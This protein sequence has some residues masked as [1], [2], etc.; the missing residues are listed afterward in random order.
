MELI[1]NE[2]IEVTPAAAGISPLG[3][4]ASSGRVPISTGSGDLLEGVGVD[5]RMFLRLRSLGKAAMPYG[6]PRPST[7]VTAGI[8]TT[9]H[10]TLLTTG[11]E[12]ATTAIV[13]SRTCSSGPGVTAE[14]VTPGPEG[15]GHGT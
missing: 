13:G 3:E 7:D 1:P 4:F 5:R 9:S 14:G 6:E 11:P 8:S 12:A 10:D 15:H 2:L